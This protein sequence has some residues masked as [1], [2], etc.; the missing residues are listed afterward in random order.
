MGKQLEHKQT[1]FSQPWGHMKDMLHAI[2]A[3]VC[4]GIRDETPMT[5][6]G[7]IPPILAIN[8]P[9]NS[10]TDNKQTIIIGGVKMGQ[11]PL[12]IHMKK[13]ILNR[14]PCTELKF[15]HRGQI[16]TINNNTVC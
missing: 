13:I 4:T 1:C 7:R 3:V 5:L 2:L 16:H 12:R 11:S 15:G 8:Q 10:C 9:I 14:C 6:T